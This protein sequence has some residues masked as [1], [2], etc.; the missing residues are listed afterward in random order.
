MCQWTVTDGSLIHSL[1]TFYIF[2]LIL[3]LRTVELLMKLRAT[4]SMWDPLP[5]TRHKWTHHALTP[6]RG[7]YLIYLPWRDGRLSWPRWLV[8]YRDGLPA[9][10]HLRTYLTTIIIIIMMHRQLWSVATTLHGVHVPPHSTTSVSSWLGFPRQPAVLTRQC[11]AGSQ[12]HDLK[13][14]I[15]SPM[16]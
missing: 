7:Q 1:F 10:T 8:T 13:L 3:P 4:L 14:L 12:T 11:T 9:A 2:S 6:A 15:T 16:P 5:S